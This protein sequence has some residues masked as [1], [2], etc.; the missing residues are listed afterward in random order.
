[1]IETNINTPLNGS[2]IAGNLGISRQAVSYSLRKS[3]GKLYK[4]VIRKGWV[5]DNSPFEVILSL[6]TI[7][8]VHNGSVD[9]VTDFIKLFSS[10]IQKSVRIDASLRFSVQS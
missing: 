10:D 3:M 9:D 4:E 5:E 2:Q 6:M 8:G 1:M 7:L